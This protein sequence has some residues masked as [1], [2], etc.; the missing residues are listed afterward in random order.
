M[1]SGVI[2]VGYTCLINFSLSAF[3][4]IPFPLPD[5]E[6]SCKMPIRPQRC[7]AHTQWRRHSADLARSKLDKQTPHV[8]DPKSHTIPS[9]FIRPQILETSDPHKT[10]DRSTEKKRERERKK[11]RERESMK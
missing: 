3:P 2:V 4:L 7:P 6:R 1:N 8:P 9:D 11:E 10:P 5:P